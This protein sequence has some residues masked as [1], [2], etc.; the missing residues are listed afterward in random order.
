MTDA[1]LARVSGL[2]LIAGFELRSPRTG[3][4]GPGLRKLREIAPWAA[5]SACRTFLRTNLGHFRG[6]SSDLRINPGPLVRGPLVRRFFAKAFE[7]VDAAA[8]AALLIREA[9]QKRPSPDFGMASETDA[10]SFTLANFSSHGGAL[11]PLK[12]G[13]AKDR[14][15]V[16]AI[17]EEIKGYDRETLEEGIGALV[18]TDEDVAENKKQLAAG[19]HQGVRRLTKA[20]MPPDA[21]LGEFVPELREHA[22]AL[23]PSG[24]R[25]TVRRCAC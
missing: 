11:V 1:I 18:L 6:R 16:R 9:E 15:G 25:D 5:T 8:G 23:A 3:L 22:R 20:L 10:L 4:P 19:N 7:R 13:F 24:S 21:R 14:A 12:A 17:A 2:Q